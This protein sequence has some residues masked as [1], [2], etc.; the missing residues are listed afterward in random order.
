MRDNIQDKLDWPLQKLNIVRRKRQEE[1]FYI[2]R[3]AVSQMQC[4]IF[5]WIQVLKNVRHFETS[6][7]ISIW[8]DIRWC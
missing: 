6:E 1:L 2:K 3:Q 7:E 5:D 4:I 8:L